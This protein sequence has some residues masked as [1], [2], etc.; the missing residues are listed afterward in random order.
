MMEI[1]CKILRARNNHEKEYI[2]IVNRQINT[3]FIQRMSNGVQMNTITK[4]VLSN[5]VQKIQ[6]HTHSGT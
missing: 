5:W 6:N 2:V 4:D 3:E 1:L